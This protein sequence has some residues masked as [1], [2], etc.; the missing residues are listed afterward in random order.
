MAQLNIRIDDAARASLD[1][2]A[3]A[4]GIQIGDLVRSLIDDAIGR[5]G[6]R[7]YGDLTPR[8]MSV[9]ERHTLAAHHRGLALLAAQQNDDAAG[10]VGGDEKYHLDVVE[11]LERGYTAEYRELFSAVVPEMSPRECDLVGDI[12]EMFTHVEAAWSRL[13]A[14][15]RASLVE[16]DEYAEDALTFRGFDLNEPFESRLAGYAR[17]LVRTGRW[18]QMAAHFDDEHEHG[19]SHARM[20]ATYQRQLDAWQPLWE[21]K[22][23]GA[24][25]RGPRAYAL[26]VDDLRTVLQAR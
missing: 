6:E 17:H 24:V 2:L 10:I 16:V 18:V 7:P 3:H 8:S 19:N 4:R 15:D 13:T 21:R 23:A 26:T 5:D 14:S 1:A 25:H 22:R 9:L 11:V 20:L 12:M